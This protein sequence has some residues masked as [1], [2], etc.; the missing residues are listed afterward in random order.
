MIITNITIKYHE[1]LLHDKFNHNHS[2]KSGSCGGWWLASVLAK[3]SAEL[4]NKL[5]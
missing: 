1:Q 2:H 3:V 4:I 5:N